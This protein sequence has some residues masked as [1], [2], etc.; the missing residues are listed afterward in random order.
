MKKITTILLLSLS[1]SVFAQAPAKNRNSQENCDAAVESTTIAGG[2]QCSA[3]NDWSIAIDVVIP[4]D[5]NLTLTS[6]TPSLGIEPGSVVAS[7]LVTIYNNANGVPGSVV[8]SP[9]VI[10]PTSSTFK[11]SQFGMDFS[12]V[13]LEL[14]PVELAG[15]AG[16]S[17]RY[18]VAIQITT[19]NGT[20]GYIEH[21]SESAIG[22]P[23]AF[24][25]G[26]GFI[27]PDATKEGVYSLTANCEPISGDLFPAPYCGPLVFGTVEPITLVEVAGISNRSSAVFN[28]TPAHEDF[29]NVMGE[30]RQGNT[31]PIALEGNTVG[32]YENRFVVF[33]DWNQNE[34]LDDEGEV[35]VIEQPLVNSTGN[36][37]VQIIGNIEVPIDAE[38]GTTRMRVKKT[39]EIP[40]TDP[41]DAGSNWGQAEDYSIVVSENL[42][43]SESNDLFGFSYFPNPVTDVL[44]LHSSKRIEEAALYNL[45]G[46]KV[47]ETNFETKAETLELANLPAGT[48]ILK[49]TID[50]KM[51]S[52]KLVK[53]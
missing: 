40:A 49:V 39:F 1:L 5:R 44:Q 42:G 22:G 26:Q 8:G 43:I 21:T 2:R 20:T 37:G 14:S 6:I 53:E 47:F 46:Q 17:I 30:M 29:V 41:C 9:Q 16:S 28:A 24:S 3:N 36:D 31:Y 7:V 34:V 10:T 50:G 38:L 32:D 33:I 13:L 25:S 27:I 45:L 18:W 4:A 19:S 23:L 15:S 52:Y 35:Y 48:Y 11:G 51:G 12:E